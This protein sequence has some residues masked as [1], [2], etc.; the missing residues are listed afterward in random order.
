MTK[1]NTKPII[2][3]LSDRFSL[4]KDHVNIVRSVF[5]KTHKS[6]LNNYHQYIQCASFKFDI[7]KNNITS[8]NDST[9]FH[10][11]W[12]W[13]EPF[14]WWLWTEPFVFLTSG[15]AA[16]DRE[17]REQRRPPHGFNVHGST[18]HLA[19]LPQNVDD[20]LCQLRRLFR[21][22]GQIVCSYRNYDDR[23]TESLDIAEL[24]FQPWQCQAPMIDYLHSGE[25]VVN[26]LA[27]FR[28][29]AMH[30]HTH[31]P[32]TYACVCAHTHIRTCHA[33][34]THTP[35]TRNYIHIR[36]I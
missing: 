14:V 7:G 22:R 8:S 12:L 18:L 2:P 6:H 4:K 24:I 30:K 34:A 25:G 19:Y 28:Y 9:L 20:V 32:C 3:Y 1:S 29:Y 35:N 36:I 17:G 16:S 15:L 27:E 5:F 26:P 13:K 10:C 31:T 11:G 23:C 21:G 33:Y